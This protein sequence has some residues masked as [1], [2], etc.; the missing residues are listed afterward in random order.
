MLSEVD[1][2]RHLF[3]WVGLVHTLETCSREE[4]DTDVAQMQRILL[5]A[6]VVASVYQGDNPQLK[7][8]FQHMLAVKDD[9]LGF[10]PEL[11]SDLAKAL[12]HAA[13]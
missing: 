12:Q 3:A 4:C 7:A 8:G 9:L 11:N 1:S 2:Y 5:D 10:Y 6:L 13:G